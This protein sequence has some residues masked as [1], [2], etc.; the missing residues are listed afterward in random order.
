M[1]FLFLPQI[2]EVGFFDTRTKT[3]SSL[4]YT[5]YRRDMVFKSD[6]GVF[7]QEEII[8]SSN[9]RYRF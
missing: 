5:L 4:P 7:S 9:T 6:E 3:L 1:A 2:Y 8:E